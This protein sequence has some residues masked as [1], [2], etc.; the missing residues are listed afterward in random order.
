[1]L[2]SLNAQRRIQGQK[3]EL[4]RR[5]GVGKDRV[6]KRG[7]IRRRMS[8]IMTSGCSRIEGDLERDCSNSLA[9]DRLAGVEMG[10]SSEIVNDLPEVHRKW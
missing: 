7:F 10:R 2:L 6:L 4:G 9:V 3:G 5:K 8:A 1:M